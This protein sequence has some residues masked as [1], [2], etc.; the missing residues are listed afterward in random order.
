MGILKVLHLN[1]SA[2]RTKPQTD[3]LRNFH[4]DPIKIPQQLFLGFPCRLSRALAY[5]LRKAVKWALWISTNM[6]LPSPSTQVVK[7]RFLTC[8]MSSRSFLHLNYFSIDSS[9]KFSYRLAK[10]HNFFSTIISS[11]Q[12]I[13]SS[14]SRS[15]PLSAAGSIISTTENWRRQLIEL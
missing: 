5:S 3:M 11:T 2:L 14:V 15:K 12:K 4:G 10:L 7:W 9:R 13:T 1:W 8:A 6:S